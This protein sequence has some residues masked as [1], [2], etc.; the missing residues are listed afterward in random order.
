M[1]RI[2]I[3]YLCDR[4][5]AWHSDYAPYDDPVDANWYYTQIAYKP[6]R[7]RLIASLGEVYEEMSVDNED[8]ERL[9][10]ELGAILDILTNM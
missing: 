2:E 8:D 6:N 5:E 7:P 10:K 3:M 1:T 9:F 4:L